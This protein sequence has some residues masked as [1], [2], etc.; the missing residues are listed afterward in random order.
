M[1]SALP[2][3]APSGTTL[4]GSPPAYWDEQLGLSFTQDFYSIAYN[5]TA[6]QQ[7]DS[8][9]YGPA[10]LLNGLSN[11]DYWYQVGLSWNWPY[12]TGGH[13]DGSVL[14]MKFLILLV[15]QYSRPM[16]AAALPAFQAM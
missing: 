14:F 8:D 9:G 10:Y 15:Y 1:A 5:V 13:Y 16:A 7:A 6:V 3:A 4:S 11:S 12:T 2:S